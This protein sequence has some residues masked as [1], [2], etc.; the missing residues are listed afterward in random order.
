MLSENKRSIIKPI[1][2]YLVTGRRSI[3]KEVRERE[4][5]MKNMKKGQEKKEYQE[6]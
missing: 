5:R 6:I 1:V 2:F 3:Y 4:D